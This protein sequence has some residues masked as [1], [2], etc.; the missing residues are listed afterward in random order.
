MHGDGDRNDH[1]GHDVH[2]DFQALPLP[3]R[4]LPAQRQDAVDLLAQA[5]GG[6]AHG[7]EVR[8]SWADSR[9]VVLPV[10]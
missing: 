6:V 3:R 8:E 5:G 9:K 7:G 1:D 2:G 4:A 10:R